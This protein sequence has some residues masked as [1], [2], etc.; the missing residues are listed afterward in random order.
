MAKAKA[1]ASTRIAFRL[2]AFEVTL[3]AMLAERRGCFKRVT[4]V[5]NQRRDGRSDFSVDY[6]G[7]M[8]EYAVGKLLKTKISRDVSMGGDDGSDLTVNEC[9]IQVKTAIGSAPLV[10][11]FFE[12]LEKLNADVVVLAVVENATDVAVAGWLM[13]DEFRA[14]ASQHDFGYGIRMAVPEEFLHPPVALCEHVYAQR[15]EDPDAQPK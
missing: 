3:L 11:L 13:A 1:A 14:L 7:V 15:Q 9:R 5:G 12:D 8:G 10:H 4:N 2:D 6:H